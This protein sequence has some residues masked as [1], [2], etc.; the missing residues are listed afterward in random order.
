MSLQIGISKDTLFVNKRK[1]TK[2][3]GLFNVSS[4]TPSPDVV[5]DL[6]DIDTIK[7]MLQKRESAPAKKC[8]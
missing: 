8:K 3:Y 1:G 7:Q 6:L 2:V 5:V 4:D